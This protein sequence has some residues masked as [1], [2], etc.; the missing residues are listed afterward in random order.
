MTPFKAKGPAGMT[1]WVYGA[2]FFFPPPRKKRH[3]SR[4][5]CVPAGSVPPTHL[6][7]DVEDTVK[8]EIS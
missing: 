6:I 2:G 1:D 5:G 4:V 8:K 7:T 3:F